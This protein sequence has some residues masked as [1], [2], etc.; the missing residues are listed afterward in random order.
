MLYPDPYDYP[1]V[2][3]C[4][5]GK[6]EFAELMHNDGGGW[7]FCDKC[8]HEMLAEDQAVNEAIKKGTYFLK[9]SK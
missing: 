5:C 9:Q 7:W 8:W 3:T 6:V 1:P 4:T 2:H